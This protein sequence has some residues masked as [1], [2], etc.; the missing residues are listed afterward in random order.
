MTFVGPYLPY[1][2]SGTCIVLPPLPLSL[3][4]PSSV[5]LTITCSNVLPLLE[6]F[7]FEASG[8]NIFRYA[9]HYRMANSAITVN[10]CTNRLIQ[11]ESAHLLFIFI[12]MLLH[13]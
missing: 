6:N 2:H 1:R 13:I 7:K 3:T 5:A 10:N 11:M 4:L 9:I 12:S 8:I